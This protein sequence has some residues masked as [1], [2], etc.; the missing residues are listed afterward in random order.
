MQ[1]KIK[2]IEKLK[3]IA[4]KEKKQGKKIILCHGTF[5]LLHIGHIKHFKEAK[6]LGDKLFVTITSDNFVNKGPQRPAFNEK[7]RLESIASLSFVDYVALSDQKTSIEVIKNLKP[8]I[9][10]KGPDYKNHKKDITGEIINEIKEVKKN[11]GKIH[12]TNDLTFSSS[13]LINSYGK[14]QSFNQK[15]IINNVKKKYNF[16]E[17]IKLIEKFKKIKVLVIGEVIIDQYVFCEAMGKSGKEP[18][19]ALKDIRSE[20][21]LGGSGAICRHLS[22]FCNKISLLTMVGEKGEFVNYI[23]KNLSKNVNFKYIK[24]KKSPT[25]IKKRFLD[26][27]NY[28]KVLGVYSINDDPLVDSDEKKFNKLL[29]KEISN[30]DL[31]IISDYGHGMISNKSAKIISKSSKYLALNAQINAANIGHHSMRNYK[32]MDCVIVNEGE[33]RH[34]MRDKN[35]QIEVLMKKFS[36]QQKVQN[37]VVTRGVEG[38]LLYNKKKF[39]ECGAFAETAVDKIGAGDAMLSI[40]S[41]FFKCGLTRELSLLAGSLAAAQSAR[42]IGNKEAVSKEK[43]FKSLEHLLK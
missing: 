42:T 6:S 1:N 31:I 13:K 10:C 20:Q 35:N 38:A 30:H 14:N 33:L 39:I 11:G 15:K 32:N 12:Y 18:M 3:K 41:L 43:I 8:N 27:I 29:K 16:S 4:L 28:N 23:R 24:K 26:Y 19:L 9:Y 7:H 34:E 37:L 2:S 17:I 25:I 36:L 5:D 40:I 21:Y 22:E